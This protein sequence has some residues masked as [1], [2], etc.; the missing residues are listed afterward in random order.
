MFGARSPL[1]VTSGLNTNSNLSL[2]SSAHKSFNTN[3]NIS[4][5]WL[6]Q[7]YVHT[8][9]C[10]IFLQNHNLSVSQLKY[11]PPQ[12]LRQHTSY[13]IEHT[14]LFQVVKNLYRFTFWNSEYKDLSSK[15]FFL[16]E[17]NRLPA[18]G[19]TNKQKNKTNKLKTCQL[20]E[21]TNKSILHDFSVSIQLTS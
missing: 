13:F 10:I 20:F 19:K 15:Y 21:K 6:I 17:R 12:Y 4:T 9:S 2:S 8:K 7:T 16:F 3:H 14:N 18:F 1:G 5:A 11:F